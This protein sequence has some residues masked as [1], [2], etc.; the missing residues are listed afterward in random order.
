M[1]GNV[2][3]GLVILNPSARIQIDRY[4]VS[5]TELFKMMLQGRNGGDDEKAAFKKRIKWVQD[6]VFGK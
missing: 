4:A 5:A 3:A 1:L 2:Y 6:I